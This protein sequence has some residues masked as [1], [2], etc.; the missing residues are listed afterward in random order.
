MKPKIPKLT[1]K[2][3]RMWIKALKELLNYYKDK[4]IKM[5]GCSLCE[6]S[7]AIT[8]GKCTM[9]K[10][11]PWYWFVN[12]SCSTYSIKNFSKVAWDL[13]KSRNR[14]WV[15]IRVDQIPRWIKKLEEDL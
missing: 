3:R 8:R 9:N 14:K 13:R 10:Y 12:I 4:G 7:V 15:E 1:K 11:C 5:V 2:E 6:I